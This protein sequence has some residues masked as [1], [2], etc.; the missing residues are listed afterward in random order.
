MKRETTV[1]LMALGAIPGH[2]ALAQ[3]GTAQ[4][5]EAVALNERT[6]SIVQDLLAKNAL[7]ASADGT[8]LRIRASAVDDETLAGL[9][10][11]EQVEI[12]P[13]TG[14]YIV[15]PAFA[16]ALAGSRILHQNMTKSVSDVLLLLNLEGKLQHGMQPELASFRSSPFF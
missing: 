6:I 7:Y 9:S 15:D 10:S 12:D 4:T 14:D 3:D 8:E 11:S 2:A 16:A 5:Q 1:I 13:A